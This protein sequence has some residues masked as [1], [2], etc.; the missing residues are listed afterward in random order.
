MK[1]IITL[2]V[3]VLIAI[4]GW[5]LQEKNLGSTINIDHYKKL[6]EEGIKTTATLKNQYTHTKGR[7]INMFTYEYTYN[8]NGKAFTKENTS[9]VLPK[10]N[11]FEITYLPNDPGI[12]ERGNPCKVAKKNKSSSFLMYLGIAM[13]L[14]GIMT[15]WISFKRIIKGA[16]K[17]LNQEP[18]NKEKKIT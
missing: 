17:P 6:C 16:I 12:S 9:N 4:F 10:T 5:N 15:A 3:G 13:L 8:V 7:L 2:I 1:K 18:K 11:N 14:I